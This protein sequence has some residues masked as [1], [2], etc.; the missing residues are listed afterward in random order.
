MTTTH[1]NLNLTAH[2][3]TAHTRQWCFLAPVGKSVVARP[4]F[5]SLY[6]FDGGLVQERAKS[7]DGLTINDRRH[8]QM[9]I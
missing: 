7:I 2:G 6:I 3:A 1:T 9:N 5:P 4:S 8:E